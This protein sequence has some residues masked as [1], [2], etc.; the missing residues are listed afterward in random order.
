MVSK[1]VT[2]YLQKGRVPFE[3]VTHRTVYTAY[4]AAQTLK[5]KLG[6]IVKSLMIK[7]DREYYLVSVPADKNVDFKLL[8]KAIKTMG[9]TAKK[10]S[11]P[12]EKELLRVFKIKP[13]TLTGFGGMHKVKTVIDKDLK[14]V[15][16][17]IVS[18]GSVTQSLR[19]KVND[20]LNLEKPIVAAIGKKRKVVVTITKKR[21]SG[22]KRSPVRRKRR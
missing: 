8:A 19:L 21:K 14:K 1:K 12:N 18:G 10:I 13:G 6:E 20:Y 16:Q 11:I 15:K 3:T 2:E 17:A 9:G 22:E 4:D 7:V 5:M